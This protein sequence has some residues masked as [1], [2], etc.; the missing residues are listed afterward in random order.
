[1]SRKVTYGD[2]VTHKYD[3]VDPRGSS[4]SGFYQTYGSNAS[5]HQ[6]AN[7]EQRARYQKRDETPEGKKW[8]VNDAG[9][10]G[11]LGLGYLPGKRWVAGKKT[12]RKRSRRT[13]KSRRHRKK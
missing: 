12:K 5:Y 9:R 6:T 2:N 7:E 4:N 13:K 11:P 10:S 8:T 3:N 1:M